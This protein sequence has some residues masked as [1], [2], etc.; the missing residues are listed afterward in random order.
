MTSTPSHAARPGRRMA[1]EIAEQPAVWHRLLVE[2]RRQLD[3][4]ARLL[5][6]RSPRFVLLLARGTSDHAALYGKYLVEILLQLPAGLV[7]PS[8]LTAYGSRPDLRDVLVLAVSQSGGSPDLVQSLDVARAQG[9]LT[10]AVTNNPSSALAQCADRHL[11]VLAGPEL[12][13]AATKSYTAQLLALYLLIDRLRGGNGSAAAA[14]PRLGEQMLAKGEEM[15]A[16]AQRYRFVQRV[17]TTARGYSY[18]TARE[19]ALKLMET[20]YL[21]A[22]AFSGADLLHGPLAMIDRQVPVLAVV[23]EGVGGAAM[24]QV[25]PRLQEAHADVFCVGSADAV[26]QFTVGVPLPAGLPEELSPLV[27]ILPFQQLAHH[28]AVMRGG[29]PDAPRGLRKVTETL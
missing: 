21:S 8:T 5:T 11:D 12:A 1:A 10:L 22:Q 28:L 19:A 26:A 3:D 16:I 14:L 20:C 15:A 2:G 29:D 9:A 4:P 7:S 24:R 25:I 6:E 13:V 23:A 27:E 17:V 18:P